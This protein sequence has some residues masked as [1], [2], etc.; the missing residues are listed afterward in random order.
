MAC[1]AVKGQ[2]NEVSTGIDMTV[3]RTG[4][5]GG[6]PPA[7]IASPTEARTPDDFAKRARSSWW[8]VLNSVIED[9]NQGHKQVG[10]YYKIGDFG[11]RTGA[12]AR[13]AMLLKNPSMR[14]I[15]DQ[16]R[17]EF[18]TEGDSANSTLWAAVLKLE[19]SDV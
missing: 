19:V 14:P 17:F 5:G 15:L 9:I 12:V 2:T 10:V 3:R 1:K 4:R 11:S 7:T 8:A 13:K 16:Y 18:R 6:Y